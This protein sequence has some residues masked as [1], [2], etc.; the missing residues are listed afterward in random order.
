M[1]TTSA[2]YSL[3]YL[4]QH[5]RTKEIILKHLPFA[6]KNQLYQVHTTLLNLRDR[7]MGGG[8]P[9]EAI[10][11]LIAELDEISSREMNAR[12]IENTPQ[13]YRGA[14]PKQ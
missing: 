9:F 5:P 7:N 8:I 2:L 10:S 12:T 6:D 3:S 13:P 4:A 14:D 1:K 11:K